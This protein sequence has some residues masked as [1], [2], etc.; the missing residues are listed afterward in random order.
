M[1]AKEKSKRDYVL[2][3][4]ARTFKKEFYY[5]NYIDSKDEFNSDYSEKFNEKTHCLRK[6]NWIIRNKWSLKEIPYSVAKIGVY[7]SRTG[8]LNSLAIYTNYG[9]KMKA[10]NV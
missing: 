5:I 1:N 2:H 4:D 9:T 8:H 3:G 6:A 10:Y 7:S